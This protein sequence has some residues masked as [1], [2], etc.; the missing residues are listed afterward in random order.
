M[1]NVV[2][3]ILIDKFLSTAKEIQAQ[4]QREKEEKQAAKK[5]EKEKYQAEGKPEEVE[6]GEAVVHPASMYVSAINMELE[7]LHEVISG[8]M[9]DYLEELM[10]RVD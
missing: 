9:K 4:E 6:D 5:K 3:A 2:L 1:A 7:K 10:G 8:T